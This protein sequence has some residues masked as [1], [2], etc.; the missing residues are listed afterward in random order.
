MP[1]AHSSFVKENREMKSSIIMSTVAAVLL[2]GVML[3]NAKAD[4][5]NKK[6]FIT[7]SGPVEVPGKVLPGG[8][9]VFK[10]L[11]SASNR[12]IVQV[13]DADEKQIY[14]TFLAIPD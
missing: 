2:A 9:Y 4:E 8:T 12:H 14:G 13:F 10:L 6:A 1:R 5:W 11:D 7:F 3:P